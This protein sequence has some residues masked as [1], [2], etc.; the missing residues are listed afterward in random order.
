[1]LPSRVAAFRETFPLIGFEVM[2]TDHDKAIAVYPS[3][4]VDLILVFRPP[5]LGD[6]RLLLEMPQRLVALLPLDHPLATRESLQ[7][8]D[9]I[10]Y[11]M[12]LPNQAMVGRQMLEEYAARHGV[13]FDVV[14]ESNSFEFLRGCVAKGGMI[15][16]Q[17][18]I[19]ASSGG[20]N[21][22]VL[23]RAISGRDMPKTNLILAQLRR[24]HLPV[25]A[26]QFAEHLR[27]SL[28]E[29]STG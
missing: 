28:P 7:L 24:R 26:A 9:C 2:I 19:G 21:T 14:V 10:G 17:M 15:S 18:E 8:L 12:A 22:P 3:Y 29:R 25:A 11:P 13:R 4:D 1:M 23:A 20:Q 27:A 16:F 6:L 5:H